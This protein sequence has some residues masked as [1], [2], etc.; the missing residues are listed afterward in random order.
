MNIDAND[1]FTKV[2]ASSNKG[3]RKNRD[4]VI[5]KTPPITSFLS[6]RAPLLPKQ[7]ATPTTS[8]TTTIVTP[9]SHQSAVP[10]ATPRSTTFSKDESS[11]HAVF[12]AN[13]DNDTFA[14]LTSKLKTSLESPTAAHPSVEQF[15][16][17]NILHTYW[18]SILLPFPSVNP[19]PIQYSST[20][21][22][23]HFRSVYSIFYFDKDALFPPSVLP[24]KATLLPSI[25]IHSKPVTNTTTLQKY[26]KPSNIAR[27]L[28]GGKQLGDPPFLRG[29]V[30][31]QLSL[32]SSKLIPKLQN[33][34][35]TWT[36]TVDIFEGTPPIVC[37]WLLNSSYG[38]NRV[39]LASQ[40]ANLYQTVSKR[41]APISCSWE[42][43]PI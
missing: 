1:G 19:L 10:P 17:S 4:E 7:T 31:L 30:K 36:I 40:L 18:L 37:G 2:A 12:V 9:S 8:K 15:P 24:Q 3:K 20:D 6:A 28:K 29:C 25:S 42:I 32:I 14:S 38:I 21:I 11:K 33:L 23:S 43:I 39:T 34:H 13:D 27:L 26:I 35:P 41:S 5:D 16:S 22:A